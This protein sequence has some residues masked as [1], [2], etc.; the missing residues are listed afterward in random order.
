MQF[1][2]LNSTAFALST[3][4]LYFIAFCFVFI[5]FGIIITYIVKNYFH[6]IVYRYM[7][8]YKNAVYSSALLTKYGENVDSGEYINALTNDAMQIERSML[9][10]V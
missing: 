7:L 8:R 4:I 9:L 1:F 6:K 2:K 5:I 3:R 10:P